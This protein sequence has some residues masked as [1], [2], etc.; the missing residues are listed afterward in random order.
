MKPVALA[1]PLALAAC[2]SLT[3]CTIYTY[4]SPPPKGKT[5]KA[6][7]AATTTAKGPVVRPGGLSKP[8]SGGSTG[9]DETPTVSGSTI[10]GGQAKA[11]FRGN[12]YVIPEGSKTMP[13]FHE[14]V[15]FGIMYTDKFNVLP[16]TFSG[17][18]PGALQQDEW[19]GIQYTGT[20]G[21]PATGKYTF[22]LV[23]DDG[24]ILYID[25]RKVVDNDGVHTAST[26]TGDITLDVGSHQLQLDYFQ[27]AK[28]SVA[29]QLYMVVG[30]QDVVVV[31]MR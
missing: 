22:K 17:G 15:P 26:N 28:G 30:G 7:P 9:G 21:V 31:G 20:I 1:V 27:A 29:L 4:S 6:K 16:Q 23:S 19:F 8:G 13:N 14:L 18:F 11:A 12:A 5:S 24:A 10:F 2:L 25:G 3:G